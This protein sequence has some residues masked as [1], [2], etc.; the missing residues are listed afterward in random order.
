MA[1]VK[2][3]DKFLRIQRI[4]KRS[5]FEKFRSNHAV[6][7]FGSFFIIKILERSVIDEAEDVSLPRIGIITPKKI[8]G[9]VERNRIRRIVREFFRINHCLFSKNSDY[10]FIALPGITDIK[11]RELTSNISKILTRRSYNLPGCKNVSFLQ[12]SSR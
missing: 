10:L 1:Q 9:A 12:K 8:G 6:V 5:D 4:R 11:S 2:T 3:R 7:L